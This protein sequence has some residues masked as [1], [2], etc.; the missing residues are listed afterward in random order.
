MTYHHNFLTHDDGRNPSVRF[1]TAHV[2]NNYY[3]DIPTTASLRA[4]GRGCAS[5]TTTFKTRPSRSA[6]TRASARRPAR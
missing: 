3:L 2:Y 6:P 1:G 5:R 4:W